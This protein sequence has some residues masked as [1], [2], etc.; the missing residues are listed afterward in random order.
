MRRVKLKQGLANRYREST[1]A[2]NL[3]LATN[4]TLGPLDA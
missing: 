3:P 2:T 1:S 4:D